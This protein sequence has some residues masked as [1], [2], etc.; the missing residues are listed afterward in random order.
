M[1]PAALDGLGLSE[2]QALSHAVWD[3]GAEVVARAMSYLLDAP[4]V[5]ARVSRLVYDCNRPPESQSAIV[6]RSELIDVP[7]NQDLSAS[8]RR[9]RVREVYE[10]FRETLA[11]TLDAFVMPPVLVTIHSFSPVWHGEPRVTEIGLLHDA[12]P[13]L[14]EAM[15]AASDGLRVELNAPYAASDGVTH[16]LA[17]H[18]IP[19]GLANVMIEIRN[20]LIATRDDA[21]AMAG[22]LSRMLL[23]ALSSGVAKGWT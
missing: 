1:I 13:S 17:E 23:S 18:A 10:P 16:T 8:A 11:R 22:K 20:D 2:D 6:A 12:D 7:G 15:L 14:A 9:A 5:A 19:R 21:E 4:L 3:P